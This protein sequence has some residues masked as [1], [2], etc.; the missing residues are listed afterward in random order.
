[1]KAKGPLPPALPQR[2]SLVAQTVQSLR[3]GIRTGHWQTY[4]PPERELCALLQVS[5]P[6][7]RAALDELLRKGWFD[8]SQRQRRRIRARRIQS[9]PASRVVALLA[10][11]ALQAMTPNQLFILY[12][13]RDK[14]ARAGYEVELCVDSASFSARPARA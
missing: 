13:L 10:P 8:V 6:T 5:R 9:A 11:C 12:T 2:L 14:L 1:M 4:L 7:L 3:E